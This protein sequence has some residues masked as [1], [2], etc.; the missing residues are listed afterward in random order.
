[1]DA[2]AEESHARHARMK[3]ASQALTK[4]TLASLLAAGVY[5]MYNTLTRGKQSKPADHA[6]ARRVLANVTADKTKAELQDVIEEYEAGEDHYA[7]QESDEHYAA[8]ESDEHYAAQEYEEDTQ[9]EYQM[10]TGM[11]FPTG[12]RTGR[13]A[14]LDLTAQVG[15]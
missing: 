2:A 11:V 14:M 10:Q 5:N 1:M 3:S 15:A 12:T 8:Q 13:Q 7:A 6:T 4:V 9:P